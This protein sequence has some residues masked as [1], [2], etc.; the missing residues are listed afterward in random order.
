MRILHLA[1]V[2]LDRP[3]VGFSSEAGNRRRRELLDA[4]RRCLELAREHKVD[5]VTIGGD[6]WEEEHVR[7]D[8][9]NSVA[10]EL[11][12]LGLPVLIACGNHDY[13]RPGGSY[14]RTT[15]PLNVKIAP[16]R[17]LTEF[18]YDEASVWAISW[19]SQ[20][21]P[22]NLLERV[23]LPP[24]GRTHVLLIHGSSTSAW[25]GEEAAYFPFDPAAVRAAGFARCL[26]GHI[27]EASD[28]GGVVYPGSPEPLGWGEGG[29]H[30]VA[31]VD[32]A[33]SDV[34]VELLDVN[35]K[36]YEDRDLDCSGCGSSAEIETQLANELTDE[37]AASVFLRLHLVGEVG[38]DCVIDPRAVAGQYAA[39]YAALRLEDATEPILDIDSRAERKGLDGLLVRRLRK[40]IEEAESERDRHLAELALQAGLRAL[41]GRDVILRVD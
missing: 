3:F 7:A 11:A 13:L 16:R 39:K 35:E 23:E 27:H 38:P 36:R 31:L 12:E 29:R 20:E 37:D 4:F 6:L 33:G 21:L 28:K 19:G 5:L 15:W 8:T 34:S 9:R 18:H 24:D 22:E 25:F 41:D 40:Q 2:H 1:D 17:T 14:R 30:C 10:H 26:A 32:L